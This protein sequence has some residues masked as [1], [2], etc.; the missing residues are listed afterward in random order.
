MSE[1]ALAGGIVLARSNAGVDT[2]LMLM[3]SYL[4]MFITSNRVRS[5]MPVSGIV[6][7]RRAG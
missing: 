7:A 5:F 1:P 2:T 3:L 4:T 6:G